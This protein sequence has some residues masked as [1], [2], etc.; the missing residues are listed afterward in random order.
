LTLDDWLELPDGP[1]RYEIIRGELVVT[2]A[3]IPFHQDVVLELVVLVREAARKDGRYR[4]YVAPVGVRLGPTDIVE[5]DICVI[6]ADKRPHR[7]GKNID[8]VPVLVVEVLSP[9]T[10][11]DDY[12]TRRATYQDAGV[13]EYWIVDPDASTIEVLTLEANQYVALPRTGNVV[14]SKALPN[15]VLDVTA[16]FAEL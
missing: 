11:R 8:A 3:P 15:L 6:P 16:F 14:Q 1:E 13:L 4:V 9:S 7:R 5:P 2:P 12:V 10:M